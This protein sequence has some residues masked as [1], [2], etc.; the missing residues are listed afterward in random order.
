MLIDQACDGLPTIDPR[1][2]QPLGSCPCRRH[3]ITL[4]LCALACLA[5]PAFHTALTV[6][7]LLGFGPAGLISGSPG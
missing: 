4:I 7:L 5:L 3:G 1:C 2:E 6:V